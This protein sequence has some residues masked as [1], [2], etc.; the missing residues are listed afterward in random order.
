MKYPLAT[1][2]AALGRRGLAGWLLYDFP[3][4]QSGGPR[5]AGRAAGTMLTRRFFYWIPARV[6]ARAVQSSV[7]AHHLPTCRARQHASSAA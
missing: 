6:R 3:R 1:V 5:A 2:Q 7:E 4:L